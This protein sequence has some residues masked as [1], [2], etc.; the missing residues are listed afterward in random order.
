MFS[1]TTK[2]V[3]NWSSHFNCV[4]KKASQRLYVIRILKPLLSHDRLV[5]VFHSLIQSLL[6]YASPVFLNAGSSLDSSFHS[7]CRRAFR[8]SHGPHHCSS[9]SLINVYNRRLSLSMKLFKGILSSPSH[10][11]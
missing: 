1:S 8:I 7:L 2:E 6:D 9:C 3:F 5:M 4:I 10:V 11:L